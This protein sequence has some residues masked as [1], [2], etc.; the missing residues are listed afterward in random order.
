MIGSQ[1]FPCMVAH[2]L[3]ERYLSECL[4]DG[5]LSFHTK[6]A[7]REPRRRLATR[8]TCRLSSSISLTVLAKVALHEVLSSCAWA[9][10]GRSAKVY[11]VEK[12][13][14]W[15]PQLQKIHFQLRECSI[16]ERRPPDLQ[17]AYFSSPASRRQHKGPAGLRT[18]LQYPTAKT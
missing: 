11:L 15:G 16:V 14:T 13:G 5:T 3:R 1:K 18:P 4:R 7:V 8:L 10:L 17:L 12:A 6:A 2:L 9:S